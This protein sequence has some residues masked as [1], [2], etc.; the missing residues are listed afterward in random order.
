MRS[1]SLTF[2]LLPRRRE[3]S[4]ERSSFWVP[5]FA[6]MI[7]L[8]LVGCGSISNS[9]LTPP[10]EPFTSIS[11][12][13]IE[14]I[15]MWVEDRWNGADLLKEQ[16]FIQSGFEVGTDYKALKHELLKTKYIDSGRLHASGPPVA[17]VNPC[18]KDWAHRYYWYYKDIIDTHNSS[19]EVIEFSIGRVEIDGKCVEGLQELPIIR[20]YEKKNNAKNK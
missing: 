11:P 15:D 13:K 9:A 12:L 18:S 1:Y 20:T 5:A 7:G 17:V 10:R 2:P 3:P 8:V 19:K 14:T 6:G 16:T 4:F